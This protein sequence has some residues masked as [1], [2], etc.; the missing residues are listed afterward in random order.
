MCKRSSRD[1]F[2]PNDDV[3][4]GDTQQA[5]AQRDLVKQVW[6]EL[7]TAQRTG[8]LKWPETIGEEFVAYMQNRKFGDNISEVMRGF[9][10][11]YIQNRFDSL[12][13]IVKAKKLAN[14][15]S[16]GGRGG[17]YGGEF[18]GEYGGYG[19]AVAAE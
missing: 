4:K 1:Q 5:Q 7:Y 15:R 16:T 9:Y 18:G 10:H 2:H 12:L 6:Q 8:V 13:E 19:G 14:G 11:N 17:G 3:I